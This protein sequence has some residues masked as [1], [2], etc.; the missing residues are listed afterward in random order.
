[1]TACGTWRSC[2]PPACIPPRTYDSVSNGRKNKNKV[3]QINGIQVIVRAR[4]GFVFL[5]ELALYRSHVVR[6]GPASPPKASACAV[7]RSRQ[8]H[9]TLPHTHIRLPQSTNLRCPKPRLCGKAAAPDQQSA[10][11][12]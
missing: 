5:L 1:M 9:L 3:Q 10:V 12:E 2:H 11:H 7:N 8:R 4:V 6:C